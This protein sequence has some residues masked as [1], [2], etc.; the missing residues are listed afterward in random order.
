[1][2]SILTIVGV[3]LAA[4]LL[5]ACTGSTSPP[6]SAT[7]T[8][9]SSPAS[10]DSTASTPEDAQTKPAGPS[11]P[12]AMGFADHPNALTIDAL[13]SAFGVIEKNADLASLHFD[14]GVPWQEAFADSPYPESFA[15]EVNGKAGLIPGGHKRLLSITPISFGRDTLAPAI[16]ADPDRWAGKGFADEEVIRA[17][18]THAERMIEAAN[19][20]FFAYAIEPNLLYAKAPA[21]WPDFLVLAEATYTSIKARYPDLPVFVTIQAETFQDDPPGQSEALRALLP[22][23]DIIA[24]STYP[25]LRISDPAAIPAGYYADIAALAPGKPFAISESGWPAEDVDDPYPVLIPS[26]SEAQDAFLSRLLGDLDEMEAV[27]FVWFLTR[28]IDEAWEQ[29][30]AALPIAPTAR[31][32]RDIGLLDGAGDARV[33]MDTWREWLA[34]PRR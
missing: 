17:F 31:L 8:S 12:F 16:G 19:P 20:D 3:F 23:T 27:F 33:A 10:D 30:Y 15:S 24:V 4:G 1:M 28:D 7:A 26:S 21:S 14:G 34:R 32:F 18:I 22:F 13:V 25:Y 9:T 5:S 6:S 11:R 29:S 2:R